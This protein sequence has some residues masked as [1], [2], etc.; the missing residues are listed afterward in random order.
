M[1]MHAR[2]HVLQYVAECCSAWLCAHH[3][4]S[5]VVLLPAMFQ[6]RYACCGV[7][8][9]ACMDVR[10]RVHVFVEGGGAGGGEGAR[11]NTNTLV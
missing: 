11:Q 6:L 1:D 8:R 7:L 5:K 4:F 9:C 3:A 2:V 10:V